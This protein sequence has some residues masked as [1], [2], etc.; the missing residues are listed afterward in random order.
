MQDK[1][2]K[3]IIFVYNDA[4]YLYRFRLS[5]MLS[6]KNKGW[7]VIAVSPYDDHAKR[8]ENKGISFW[9]L[10]LERKGKNPFEDI[11][12]F[13]RLTGLYIKEKPFIVHHF[14]VKPVIYGTLAAR[15]AGIPGIVNL[16]PG[17]GYVFFRGGLLQRFVEI[18]YRISFA[19][20]VRVI[21]QNADDL[22]YFTR[23]KLVNRQQTR[24][25]C[26]SG[27]NM[28][29]FD[30]EKFSQQKRPDTVIFTLVARMLWDKGIAEFADAAKMVH[31]KNAHTKFVLLG[32]PDAGNPASVPTSWLERL[33]KLDFIDWIKHRENIRPILAYSSVVVLPSYREG[34]PR[35]L[36]EAAAMA[37]PIITTD[38]PGCREI[39]ENGTNGL[40][41]PKKN[42]ASLAEAMLTLAGDAALRR[43]ME[44][45]SR[46][47]ALKY[48][49]ERLI[50]QQT[51]KI[52]AELMKFEGASYTF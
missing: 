27:I 41:V 2:Q 48:F 28:D 33:Q 7:E 45:S 40:L 17:L 14:T 39:V 37:K 10:P 32:D 24:L 34:A 18:M 46:E 30:P 38:V 36:I 35:A 4:G 13:F 44:K 47:R 5:L 51:Q 19:P 11:R 21:F 8:I 12:V 31:Q 42:A 6:M 16:I 23:R 3:K 1:K 49:D 29:M 22:N 50:I 43:R 20:R 9:K 25:I 15:F 26:G 52:Y